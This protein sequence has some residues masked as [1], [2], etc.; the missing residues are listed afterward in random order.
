MKTSTLFRNIVLCAMLVFNISVCICQENISTTPWQQLIPSEKIPEDVLCRRSNN[1]LDIAFYKNR[2][3]IAFR[4]A[5][6]HFA[7]KKSALH[8]LSSPDFKEWERETTVQLGTDVREPRFCVFN[9]TLRFFF[10][11]AGASMFQFQPKHIWYLSCIG[12]KK[13]TSMVNTDL[14]GFVP[15]RIRTYNGQMLLSAYYG[16]NLYKAGHQGNLRLFTSVDGEHQ[17]PISDSAQVT[18]SGAEEGEFIIDSSGTL[19]ATVRLE[20]E[21]ALICKAEKNHL[22]KWTFIKSKH[23]YDSALMFLHDDEVYLVSR[24]NLDGEMDK[25]NP[26]RKPAF[27]KKYNLIRYSLTKKTTSLFK[28]NKNTLELTW[29]M[30]FPATG[31]NA[32]PGIVQV[33]EHKFILLNYTNDPNKGEKNWIRGQLGKTNIYWTTLEFID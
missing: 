26:K 16:V 23:K 18:V 32:F 25:A 4:T 22:D 3:Y 19:F 8:I 1:N 28:L 13:W 30:D 24:R 10:F 14:D 12:D 27:R 29:I 11:E 15:W 20:S 7:S 17:F 2:Y 21:G 6:T 31:D 33:D 9:D 5:P